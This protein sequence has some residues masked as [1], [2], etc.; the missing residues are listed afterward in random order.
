MKLDI[1]IYKHVS[2][3]CEVS[4]KCSFN[5]LFPY[6][7]LNKRFFYEPPNQNNGNLEIKP[8]SS[9]CEGC[10]FVLLKWEIT[11]T[12]IRPKYNV[13]WHEYPK[14]LNFAT[15]CLSKE[16]KCQMDS[17]LNLRS[18]YF[19]AFSSECARCLFVLFLFFSF[20]C[21]LL[22]LHSTYLVCFSSKLKVKFDRES[23]F[24]SRIISTQY[25]RGNVWKLCLA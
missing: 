24:D 25:E 15:S 6:P 20:H 22:L 21:I 7:M 9:E 14:F 11:L 18:S 5:A 4:Q 1:L 16:Q 12:L 23:S 3:H 10:L 13:E 8:F 17:I 2:S 19:S